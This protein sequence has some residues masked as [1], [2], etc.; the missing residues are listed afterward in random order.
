MT[1]TPD[2][3]TDFEDVADGLEAVT[4]TDLDGTETAVATALR[5]HQRR[6]TGGEGAGSESIR[7]ACVWHLPQSLVATIPDIGGTITD[8][9]SLVWEIEAV[10]RQ[11]FGHRWR[12]ECSRTAI[13]DDALNTRVQIMQAKFSQGRHGEP[14][15]EWKHWRANIRAAISEAELTAAQANDMRY[16]TASHTIALDLDEEL[17]TE[18]K[19]VGG[20]GTEYHILGVSGTGE[21]GKPQTVTCT[22]DPTPLG[23]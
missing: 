18:H 21:L 11:V 3:S 6:S 10:S 15:I 8:T 19:I 17:T 2:L 7:D 14:V 20:D 13:Q 12:C 4:M 22:T 16:A 5:R 23:H 9:D 1:I